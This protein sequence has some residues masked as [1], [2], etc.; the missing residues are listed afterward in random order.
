MARI[1]IIVGHARAGTYCEAL[2]EHYARVA[3]AG[4]HEAALF[5]TARMRFDPALRE[6]FE[7][8]QPHEP[9]SSRRTTPFARPITWC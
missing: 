9:A 3:K 4:G 6:G 2:G 1:A 7:R 8:V 5:A